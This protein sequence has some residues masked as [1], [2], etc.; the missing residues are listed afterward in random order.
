MSLAERLTTGTLADLVRLQA[1]THPLATA[2]VSEGRVWPYEGLQRGIMRLALMLSD[3][4]VTQGERV[5]L[6]APTCDSFVVSFFALVRLGAIPVPLNPNLLE[7]EVIAHARDCHARL[8]LADSSVSETVREAF[9]RACDGR[10]IGLD[11][12]R[13][14]VTWHYESGQAPPISYFDLAYDAA[15][16][17]PLD[18]TAIAAILYTSGTT[19]APKGVC[20]THRNLLSNA[21]AIADVLPVARYSTSAVTLPLHHASGLTGQ[22]LTTLM[23]GGTAHLFRNLAF[24][25][26]VLAQIQREAIEGFAAF[27]A[28]FRQLAAVSALNELDLSCVRYLSIAG[29]PLALEDLTLIRQI[30][31]RARVYLGYGL[32][33]AGPRVATLSEQDSHFFAGSVG[34]PLPGVSLKVV[35]DGREADPDEVGELWVKGP[36]VMTSYWNNPLESSRVLEDGWLRTGDRARLDAEGYL[37]VMGRREHLV[38]TTGEKLSPT[39]IEVVLER[40]PKV[41]EAAVVA[42]PDSVL[43]E[44]LVACVVPIN[45]SVDAQDTHRHCERHLARHKIPHEFRVIDRLPKTKSGR[46]QRDR[47]RAWCMDGAPAEVD[48]RAEL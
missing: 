33:E 24:P 26:P 30:F 5:L 9:I 47:L 39:E 8:L 41:R 1:E 22:L 28:T 42:V 4:G 21:R 14:Q 29:S 12:R 11:P 13:Q 19:G 7:V 18:P 6:M 43:G 20:L 2:L 35:V 10:V 40:H 27:P 37:F 16:E 38:A 46:V 31:P 23:V 15:P 17:V 3:G 32:T 44:R 36:G 45:G 34:R 48:P 25:F